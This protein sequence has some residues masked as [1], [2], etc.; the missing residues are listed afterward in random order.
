MTAFLKHIQSVLVPLKAHQNC[1]LLVES[2]R[3]SRVYFLC[4]VE[5][6]KGFRWLLTV[7]ICN[8][9]ISPQCSKLAVD[10]CGLRK[11][12]VCFKVILLHESYPAKAIPRVVVPNI[13][14]ESSLVAPLSSL[15]VGDSDIFVTCKSVGICHVLIC[16]YGLWKVL[17]RSFVFTLKWVAIANDAHCF[18]KMFSTLETV[19]G[20]VNQRFQS[21]QVPQTSAVVFETFESVRLQLHWFFITFCCL[22]ILHLFKQT[23][24]NQ[25]L[26]PACLSLSA[27]QSQ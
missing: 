8:S 18:W 2:Q 16:F 19:V 20:K 13:N 12:A 11:L 25:L 4:L 5:A 14:V 7:V 6:L 1:A 22:W 24:G 17:K 27:R 15:V 21:F 9:S 3:T 23:P 26:D 10:I